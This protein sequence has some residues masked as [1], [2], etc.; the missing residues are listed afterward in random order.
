[1]ANGCPPDCA[2]GLCPYPSPSR[3]PRGRG[4]L[5]AAFCQAQ[6]DVAERLGPAPWH[7]GRST[8]PQVDF[9][10]YAEQSLANR[11]GWEINL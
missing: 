5:S 2:F 9:W 1:M 6:H 8:Q 7:E 11:D 4:E 10:L 3:R